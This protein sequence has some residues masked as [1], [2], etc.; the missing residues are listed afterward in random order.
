MNSANPYAAYVASL[1]PSQFTELLDAVHMRQCRDALGIGTLAEAAD[2]FRPH[3]KCPKCESP[4]VWKNGTYKTS[5]ISRYICPNCEHRF[6][7]LS[8]TIFESSKKELYDWLCFITLMRYNVPLEAIA[9]N[10]NITHQTAWEW[11]HRVFATI[12]GYQEKIVL[13]ERIWID[14]IYITDTDLEKGFGQAKKRGLSKQKICIAVAIDIHKNPVAIVC[15]HGKPSSKRI[16]DTLENHIEQNSVIVH[17]KERAHS[18]LIKATGSISE[19]Y[20]ADATDPI[21]LEQMELINNL[22]S[23]LKRYLWCFTGMSP[24]NLQSYLNWFVYLFRV[25]QAKDM[26]PQNARVLRHLMLED[27]CFRTKR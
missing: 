18:A 15:G 21:Y 6:N 4:R 14:E 22:S 1:T 12:D 2:I 19:S 5:G 11:R 7:S 9:E 17:D 23:W 8:N 13:K 20:K 27:A 24:K 3:P 25:N 26:W 10:M 16:T